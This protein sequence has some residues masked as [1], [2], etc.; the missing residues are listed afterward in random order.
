MTSLVMNIINN[1][2]FCAYLKKPVTRFSGD[3]TVITRHAVDS[4]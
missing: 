2:Q 3:A 1:K 4:G